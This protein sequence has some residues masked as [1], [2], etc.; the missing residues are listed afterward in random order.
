[1]SANIIKGEND[2]REFKYLTLPNQMGVLLVSDKE[3]EKSAAAMD[4]AVGNLQDY[5]ETP[6]LAHFLEHMLFLGTEKY[7]RQD[8]YD[9]FLSQ[10]SGFSNA[11]TSTKNTNY[12]F[13]VA[14][15]GFRQALDMFSQFFISPLFTEEL[16]ER[17]LKAVDSEYKKNLN[18]DGRRYAQL[19][20]STSKPDQPFNK[21]GSGNIESLSHPNVRDYLLRFYNEFYS[22]NLM[23]CVL[24]GKEDLATLESWAMELFSGIRVVDGASR[25]DFK[26]VVA[27]DNSNMSSF[28]EVVPIQDSNALR[29]FWVIENMRPLYKSNPATYITHLLRHQGPNSL[30]SLLRREGLATGISANQS[31]E[32]RQFSYIELVV[33]LTKG[34]LEKYLDVINYVFAYLQMLK[35]RGPQKWIF[36]EIQQIENLHF[37]FYDKSS[38]ADGASDLA[39]TINEYPAE[40]ALYVNCIFEEFK[41]DEIRRVLES[42]TLQNLRIY[43]YSK[44]FEGQTTHEE[45]WYGTKYSVYPF[46]SSIT[47]LFA[48]PTLKNLEDLRLPPRNRFIPENLSLISIKADERLPEYPQKIYEDDHAVLYYKQDNKFFKPKAVVRLQIYSETVFADAVKHRTVSQIW[49]HLWSEH[50]REFEYM[51]G[52]ASLSVSTTSVYGGLGVYAQG[53]NDA[54]PAVLDELFSEIKK[55]KPELEKFK[56][57]IEVFLRTHQNS[58]RTQPQS[59]VGKFFSSYMFTNT[60]LNDE[61][62]EVLPTI[63]FED[64]LR[65]H[66]EWLTT[67]R[68]DCFATGNLDAESAKNILLH[69]QQNIRN[70]RTTSKVLLKEDYPDMRF[71]ALKNV[72]HQII[73]IPLSLASE[74]N[75]CL[76]YYYQIGLAEIQKPKVLSKLMDNFLH[77]RTFDQLRTT[78]S[79]GYVV[80]TKRVLHN[81]VLG[82][83]IT[84]QSS[85]QNPNYIATRIESHINNM[86][87]KIAELSDEEFKNHVES[88]RVGLKKADLS[89]FDEASRNWSEIE[90]H[91]YEFDWRQMQ[92]DELDAATKGDLI[93]FFNET[94]GESTKKCLEFHAIAQVH[95]EANKSVK[96]ERIEMN[97]KITI[98]PSRQAFI[99]NAALYPDSDRFK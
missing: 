8:D 27:F 85:V 41:P 59:Q 2:H 80:N 65:F 77:E 9:S 15:H 33:S 92:L 16:T 73:E 93:E 22:A 55:F 79:L 1:M 83:T 49:H 14:N 72:N 13:E 50:L 45:K 52:L 51:V 17:E 42:L 6:G 97:P 26:D 25:P 88:L 36:E 90:S 63:T 11:Y 7:P 20:R 95:E 67:T 81:N 38:P 61:Y 76:L 43:F 66:N 98:A 47:S 18:N 21:F 91:Q 60:F 78:E 68:I 58:K 62:S 30:L 69:C 44:N 24:Y 96:A 3:T 40:H 37:Q 48:N 75:S 64:L 34:G 74:G 23:K 57:A 70:L 29:F 99:N 4:V 56:L 54:I 71:V 89:I 28:W 53:F 12:Y 10:N 46:P 87:A 94:F 32:M 31:T 82:F 19:M 39:S 35:E 5:P 86:K 84:V